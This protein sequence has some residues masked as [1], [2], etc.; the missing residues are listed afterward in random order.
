MTVDYPMFRQIL[1]VL[2]E[3]GLSRWPSIVVDFRA[4]I[5]AQPTIWPYPD[6]DPLVS[7][8]PI[9]HNDNIL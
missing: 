3:Q 6:I 8:P 7:Y 9:Y 5:C 1:Q 2:R 4:T